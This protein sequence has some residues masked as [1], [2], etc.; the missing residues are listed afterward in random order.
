MIVKQSTAKKLP[1]LLYDKTDFI[2][3]ET[4]ITYGNVT[5]YIQKEDGA[6][7]EKT[8]ASEDWT[9]RGHGIYDISFTAAELNTLGLFKYQVTDVQTE[10]IDYNGVVTV[11]TANLSDLDTD[12]AA[13][14]A[15]LNT[16]IST[17]STGPWTTY[18]GG[19]GTGQYTAT[20]NVKVASVN[21]ADAK[22]T[23]H[24]ASNDDD[25]HY[26]PVTTDINGNAVFTIE[27]NVYVRVSK[28]GYSFT[29]TAKNITSTATYNV[30]GTAASITP[31]SDP[32]LCRLVLFPITLD[33][34]DI[35]DLV[36]HISSEENLTKVNGEFIKHAKDTFTINTATDPDSYYYDAVQGAVVHIWCADLGIDQNYITVPALSTVDL[37][38]LIS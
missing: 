28:V 12:I 30:T 5:V 2:T 10:F 9:E 38:T 14:Q 16:I 11:E 27:G 24:N 3:P 15:D 7:S 19:L 37:D 33:N 32:D 26:G 34:L 36:I 13:N 31:P 29:A 23:I 35:A 21:V 18:D 4:G 20:I 8:L 6:Q 25:P 17:G 1:C 22:V